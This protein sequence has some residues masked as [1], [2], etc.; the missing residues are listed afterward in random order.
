MWLS[1]IKAIIEQDWDKIGR[2]VF[3]HSANLIGS[4]FSAYNPNKSAESGL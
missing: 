1:K 2:V 3:K 4:T